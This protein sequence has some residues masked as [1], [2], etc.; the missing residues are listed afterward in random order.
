MPTT[1]M[2]ARKLLKRGRAEIIKYRPFTIRMLDREDGAVQPIEYKCDTGY[3]TI[4]ISICSAK[5]EFFSEERTL[6]CGEK[7]RH[8]DRRKYR[9]GRRS[10]KTRHRKPRF[11]NRRG[12]ICEDG[13]APSMRNRRDQH[14]RLFEI[15]RA[16]VPITDAVFEMSEFDTQVLAAVEAGQPLPQ[17]KDYQ[18]GHRYG[19]NT[20]RAAVFARDKHTCQVCGRSIAEGAVLRVHHLGFRSG[21]HTDRMGNLLTVCTNCHTPRHHKKGGKLWDLKPSIKPF[22]GATFMTSV[23]WDIIRRLKDAAPDVEFHFVYGAATKEARHRLHLR[24]THANDAWAMGRFHPKHRTKTVYWQKLRRNNRILAKFYD[25]VYIDLRDKKRKKG[26]ELPC[27]RTRRCESRHGTGNERKC[28]AN[29]VKKGRVS[30]RRKRYPIRP[31]DTVWFGRERFEVR[32]VQH[33][34]EYVALRGQKKSCPVSDVT[35]ICHAGGW[36]KTR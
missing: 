21:D 6:L 13:F 32:G 34:G 19:Y 31:G 3:Q 16:V 26:A 35:K 27:G 24:K 22:T 5:R 14:I 29:K 9:A 30:L 33:Y 17:G 10:R 18:H 4:G 20:L 15:Y 2:R 1:E 7:E 28:R 12:M 23:R 36:L 11:S 25:A 8:D